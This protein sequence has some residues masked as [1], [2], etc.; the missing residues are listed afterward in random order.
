MGKT[1][2]ALYAPPKSSDLMPDRIAHL[3]TCR[4]NPFGVIKNDE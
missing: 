1:P 3:G 4:F 2:R